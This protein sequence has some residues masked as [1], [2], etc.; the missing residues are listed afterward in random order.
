MN[1]K[2]WNNF[3]MQNHKHILKPT[4]F[5]KFV[6][7]F[8][9]DYNFSVY[10]IGCGNGRDSYYLSK[11]W[12]VIGIDNA[13]FPKNKGK[14]KF[15][16][17]DIKEVINYGRIKLIYARF[18]FH[19]IDDETVNDILGWACRY[20]AVEVRSANDDKNKWTYQKHKRILRSQRKL[21][22]MFWAKGYDIMFFKEGKGLAKYKREDPLI[23]RIIAKKCFK[24]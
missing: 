22:K 7:K 20:V 1:Q 3:Y 5:A 23:I 18:F 14:A 11:K 13:N 15:R 24:K 16:K 17:D 4:K 12:D 8:F 2:Y 6:R 9:K 10:D 21:I 19:S